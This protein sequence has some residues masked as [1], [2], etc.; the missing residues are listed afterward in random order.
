METKLSMHGASSGRVTSDTGI[1]QLSDTSTLRLWVKDTWQPSLVMSEQG[2]LTATQ[3]GTASVSVWNSVGCSSWPI[4]GKAK[5]VVWIQWCHLWHC[6][7]RLSMCIYRMHNAQR[8]HPSAAEVTTQQATP[9]R[10]HFK[11]KLHLMSFKSHFTSAWT[12]RFK[13]YAP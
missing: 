4:R 9:K 3:S 7:L 8:N 10:E 5:A 6:N 13:A 12:K 2:I 1:T 11:F